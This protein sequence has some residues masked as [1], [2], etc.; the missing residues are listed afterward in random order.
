MTDPDA[1]TVD[2]V[3]AAADRL[4]PSELAAELGI[5]IGSLRGYARRSPAG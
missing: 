4:P 3:R 1:E 5:T 2:G